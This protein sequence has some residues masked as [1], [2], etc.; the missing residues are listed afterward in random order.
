MFHKDQQRD[1]LCQI[2]EKKK[3]MDKLVNLV[4]KLVNL[5]QNSGNNDVTVLVSE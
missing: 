5:W 3:A 1:L 2:G 4:N